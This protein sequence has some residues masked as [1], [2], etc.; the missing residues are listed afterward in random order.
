LTHSLL[1]IAR[2]GVLG[3]FALMV[4]ES[5]C[6]TISSEVTLLLSGFAVREEWMSRGRWQ[7][8]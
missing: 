2:I 3:V 4:S 6:I 5:A 1:T 7:R 8:D